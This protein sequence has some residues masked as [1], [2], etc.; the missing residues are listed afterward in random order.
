MKRIRRYAA[1]ILTTSSLLI[2][3]LIAACSSAGVASDAT[4]QDST[5]PLAERDV[6]FRTLPRN[7]LQD[8]KDIW[9]FPLQI[10]KGREW[11]PTLAVTGITAGLI[12]A[13]PYDTPYFRRTNDWLQRRF[14][15]T[16]HRR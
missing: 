5:S 13:D 9:L 7:F 6:S 3:T 4:P 8:Q 1:P 14:L 11:L 15:R 10:T 16:Y 2:S 12:V